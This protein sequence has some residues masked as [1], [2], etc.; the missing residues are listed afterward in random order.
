M[1]DFIPFAFLI[2]SALFLIRTVLTTDVVF[3]WK[4]ILG[5][6]CLPIVGFAFWYKHKI[7]VLTLG[8]TLLVGWAGLLSFSPSIKTWTLFI[9][10]T[11]GSRLMVFYAQPIFVWW[12]LIHCI[13]SVRHYIGIGTKKYWNDLLND[14]TTNVAA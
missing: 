8:F 6:C 1:L 13:I 11:E 4:H 7:G 12:L 2:V 10:Q 14:K 9:G 5:F 3:Q